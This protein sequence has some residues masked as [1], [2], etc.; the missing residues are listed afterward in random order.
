MAGELLECYP[1]LAKRHTVEVGCNDGTLLGQ[2]AGRGCRTTGI[3]PS[4]PA[5]IPGVGLIYQKPFTAELAAE[6]RQHQGE[7]GLVIACNVAAHVVDPV[8]FLR[9]IR[10]LLADDGVAVVEF[11]DVAALLTGCQYDHVYH[12]HR[13]FYS[14]RSF[15]QTAL[16]AGLMVIHWERTAVQ[17]GSVRVALQAAG[18]KA[19]CPD[20]EERLWLEDP[21]VYASMQGRAE[22]SRRRLLILIADELHQG[23]A[24]A[25]WGASAKSATLLNYCGLTAREIRWVEDITPEKIGRLTPGSMIP[26]RAPGIPGPDTFLLTSWNYASSVVRDS[27]VQA[28]LRN[29]GRLIVPGAIPVTL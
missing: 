14:L 26:I 9:G 13:F 3:D 22:W 21:A 25:G 8:D 28:F 17:G 12:E 4:S 6:V 7:A 29:R 24:I 19:G 11:Q 23:R 10:V 1:E 18:S 20:V 16:R 2:F 5:G 15:A 27:Q